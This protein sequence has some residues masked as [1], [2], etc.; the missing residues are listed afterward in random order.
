VLTGS[1]LQRHVG[2]GEGVRAFPIMHDFVLSLGSIDR[3]EDS[4]YVG[5]SRKSSAAQI[6]SPIV[7]RIY[8]NHVCLFLYMHQ[9]VCTKRCVFEI[10]GA[11]CKTFLL[12]PCA[13]ASRVDLGVPTSTL[14]CLSQTLRLSPPRLSRSLNRTEIFRC[15]CLRPTTYV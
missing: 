8:I 15:M 7:L 4:D 1:Q 6:L 2:G 5:H 12:L 13:P 11:F 3:S 14:I 9:F 10:R